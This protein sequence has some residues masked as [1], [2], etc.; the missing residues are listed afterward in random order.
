MH[1]SY[2]KVKTETLNALIEDFVSREG[3]EYGQ[4]EFSLTEKVDQVKAQLRS[5]KA[6]ISYNPE[7]ETCTI[8][9]L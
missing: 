7:D 8:V 1:I 4:R 9:C 3:T 6:T 2:E 5:G